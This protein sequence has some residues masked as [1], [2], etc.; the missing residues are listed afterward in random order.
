MKQILVRIDSKKDIFIVF[1]DTLKNGMFDV[2]SLADGYTTASREWIVSKSK[3]FCKIP[4]ELLNRIDFEYN[5][6]K[7]MPVLKNDSE[8]H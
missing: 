3:N 6:N 1:L 8:V 5:V 4:V 7:R 2:F